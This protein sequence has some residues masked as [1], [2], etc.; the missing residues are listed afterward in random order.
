MPMIKIDDKEYDLDLLSNEV[1][2]QLASLNFVDAELQRLNAQ[3]AVFQTARA[4]YAN[5]LKASLPPTT[6]ELLEAVMPSVS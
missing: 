2:N 3:I 6:A 4:T 1:K 5:A